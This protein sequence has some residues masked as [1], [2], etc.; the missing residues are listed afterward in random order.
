[1]KQRSSRSSPLKLKDT[2]EG[3]HEKWSLGLPNTLKK[4]CLYCLSP[5]P[6][7]L[8]PRARVS[9]E[10][11]RMRGWAHIQMGLTGWSCSKY[12]WTQSLWRGMEKSAVGCRL[13]HSPCSLSSCPSHCSVSQDGFL[14]CHPRQRFSVSWMVAHTQACKRITDWFIGF[15]GAE[16]DGLLD[17]PWRS[18]CEIIEWEHRGL[19][20]EQLENNFT[21]C[22]HQ[23]F[24]K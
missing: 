16:V 1:M 3:N 22:W 23:I 18:H 12:T 21:A 8:L 19:I 11:G 10:K 24:W 20:W 13:M 14:G 9:L 17:A 6:Y 7:I 5:L 2:E 15:Q 4:S